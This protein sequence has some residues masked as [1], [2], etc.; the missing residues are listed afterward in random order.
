MSINVQLFCFLSRFPPHTQHEKK[1]LNSHFF[2]V[3][4]FWT[5]WLLFLLDMWEWN[6]LERMLKAIAYQHNPHRDFFSSIKLK[7]NFIL[8]W[9]WWMFS[10]SL[11]LYPP[12]SCTCAFATWNFYSFEKC[13]SVIYERNGIELVALYG[14]MAVYGISSKHDTWFINLSFFLPEWA[15]FDS[16]NLLKLKLLF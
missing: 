10:G 15:A 5:T 3:C 6:Q 12:C 4:L 8:I 11:C 13:L 1:N 14:F 9:L 16:S 2:R 7:K